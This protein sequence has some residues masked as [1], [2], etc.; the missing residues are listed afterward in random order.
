MSLMFRTLCLVL[1]VLALLLLA[2]GPFYM[3]LQRPAAARADAYSLGVNVIGL[4][5]LAY[6]AAGPWMLVRLFGVFASGR[7]FVPESGRWLKR[8]GF[9]LATAL[10]VPI[11]LR[12]A[13]DM[14][15]YGAL[16]A[17]RDASFTPVVGALFVGL[18]LIMLGWVLE[19]GS[20]LQSEQDLTV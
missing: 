13:L 9:W 6:W 2:G 7:I 16:G 19:E 20:E 4:V 17:I 10:V 11:V 15:F 12:M 3:L 5:M 1:T 18:F 14:A 8:F